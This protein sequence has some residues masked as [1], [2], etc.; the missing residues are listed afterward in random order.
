MRYV[1]KIVKFD[2]E[3]MPVQVLS[4]LEKAF[5]CTLGFVNLVKAGKVTLLYS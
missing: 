5:L 4:I 1:I 2:A 3:N